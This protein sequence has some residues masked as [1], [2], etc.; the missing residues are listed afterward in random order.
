MNRRSFASI[1]HCTFVQDSYLHVKGTAITSFTNRV[2]IEV[3]HSTFREAGVKFSG[4]FSN[5]SLTL[6]NNTMSITHRIN[7]SQHA[8][9]TV[10]LFLSDVWL[11]NSTSFN[12]VANTISPADIVKSPIA[13]H[14]SIEL[15]NSTF[16]ISYNNMTATGGNSNAYTLLFVSIT[17]TSSNWHIFYNNLMSTGGSDNAYTL[18][19]SQP[20]TITSSNWYIS[21]NNMTA[22]SS[23]SFTL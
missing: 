7:M 17:M 13:L 16:L 3:L 23:S 6:R 22:T 8:S 9:Y 10:P 4:N 5:A 14:G 11:T 18:H 19:F 1:E 15:H 12:V 21:Y 20:I 2:T